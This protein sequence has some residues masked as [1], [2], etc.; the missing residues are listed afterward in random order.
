[1]P[2]IA[3]SLAEGATTQDVATAALHAAYLRRCVVER[4]EDLRGQSGQSKCGAVQSGAGEG[5]PGAGCDAAG[6]RELARQRRA[7]LEVGSLGREELDKCVEEAGRRA[8][9]HAK[10]FLGDVVA[11]GWQTSRLLLSPTERAGYALQ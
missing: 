9:R 11:A 5:Q 6:Q 10:R 3:I 1:V 4:L 2:H 7:A 8:R